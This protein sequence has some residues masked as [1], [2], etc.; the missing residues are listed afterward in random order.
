[1]TKY[2]KPFAQLTPQER[3]TILIDEEKFKPLGK[4]QGQRQSAHELWEKAQAKKID[5]LKQLRN[6]PAPEV[7]LHD[8]WTSTLIIYADANKH[9]LNDLYGSTIPY[10]HQTNIP[11]Q[12]E[13]RRRIKNSIKMTLKFDNATAKQQFIKWWG[14]QKLTGDPCLAGI[15][16]WQPRPTFK[17]IAL[18]HLK[19]RRGRPKGAKNKA[20]SESKYVSNQ[21]RNLQQLEPIQEAT[22]ESPID[23]NEIAEAMEDDENPDQQTEQINTWTVA[24]YYRQ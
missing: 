22:Q 1:M 19:K 8:K 20:P 10:L 3:A 21:M 24:N 15:S 4:D 14:S 2:G 11:F 16:K 7:L 12:L 17:A 9:K 6:H 18:E 13:G 5:I 23:E